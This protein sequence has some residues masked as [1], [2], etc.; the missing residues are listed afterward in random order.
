MRGKRQS[1]PAAWKER[2][3]FAMVF[4]AGRGKSKGG[5][6]ERELRLYC[7]LER[8]ARNPRMLII[9]VPGERCQEGRREKRRIPPS[10]PFEK[11]TSG[12][13]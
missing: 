9:R 8:V 3:S 10:A 5:R 13:H 12:P 7:P 4:Q 6:G 2:A 11:K 1:R